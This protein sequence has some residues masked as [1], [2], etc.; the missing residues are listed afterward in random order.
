MHIEIDAKS[1]QDTRKWLDTKQKRV[2]DMRPVLLKIATKMVQV[3]KRNIDEPER[4]KQL[5]WQPLSPF[6]LFV[7]RHRAGKQDKN[8]KP[9]RDT[10]KLFNSMRPDIM[11]G[12][13]TA[14][15]WAGTNLPYARL[16]NY[17]GVGTGGTVTIAGYLRRSK[18]G[19][20][21]SNWVKKY[22]M[23]IKAGHKIPARPFMVM[24]DNEFEQIANLIKDYV[25][26]S[27][28]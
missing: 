24:F 15:A 6:T 22:D 26:G 2:A 18:K 9:L 28:K 20:A 7:K 25:Y 23:T 19:Y 10:G 13:K 8:P 14:E 3:I 21:P 5:D 27:Q 12:E 17:G 11:D 1:L 16:Q 4:Q